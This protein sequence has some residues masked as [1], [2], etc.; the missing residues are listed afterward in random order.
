MEEGEVF[1][2]LDVIA[3]SVYMASFQIGRFIMMSTRKRQWGANWWK[4]PVRF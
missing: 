3:K 2:H 4:L 1:H